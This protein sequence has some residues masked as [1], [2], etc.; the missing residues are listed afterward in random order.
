MA[1]IRNAGLWKDTN[2]QMLIQNEVLPTNPTSFNLS[3]DCLL[4]KPCDYMRSDSSDTTGTLSLTSLEAGRD[5]YCCGAF[6]AISKDATCDIV[7]GGCSFSC[8]IGGKYTQLVTVPG[9]TLT[10]QTDHTEINFSRPIKIDRSSTL[11]VNGTF[12]AGNL[13]RRVCIWGFYI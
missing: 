1:Q 13:Y 11:Q 6:L 4:N 2:D 9:R 3:H 5:F 7:T 10:V 8:L 12:A